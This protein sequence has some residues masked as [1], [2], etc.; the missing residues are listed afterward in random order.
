MRRMLYAILAACAAVCVRAALAQG[1][2]EQPGAPAG[3]PAWV[4]WPD[5]G[6]GSQEGLIARLL[7]RDEAVKQLGLTE[8]QAAKLKEKA[9]ALEQKRARLKGELD[10]AAMEQAKLL[11][12]EPVQAEALMAAV[13]KTGKLRTAMAKLRV[14]EL[15]LVKNG[16]TPEQRAK[17]RELAAQR[18]KEWRSVGAG[19]RFR[20]EGDRRE[21]QEFQQWRS[22]SRHARE[23][24]APGPG[25]NG[26][27]EGDAPRGPAE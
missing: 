26:A 2:A 16:L 4:P 15:L 13:E 1:P 11:T 27:P 8:E 7:R 12:D 23:D 9:T 17:L 3:P 18:T 20:D 14:Q 22:R 25:T 21:W 24:R 6:G 19:P 5:V 10:R